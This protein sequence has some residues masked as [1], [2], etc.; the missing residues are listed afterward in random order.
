MPK[1]DARQ[2]ADH[3]LAHVERWHDLDDKA[4]PHSEEGFAGL[5]L[6][7]SRFNYWL[8]HEEDE[9]RRTDVDDAVIARVKRCLLYT[10]DAADE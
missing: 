5:V 10:S 4:L 7:Q 6:D 2:I 3:Q 1:P 8:W 9:A